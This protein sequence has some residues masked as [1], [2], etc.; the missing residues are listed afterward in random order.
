M[1]YQSMLFQVKCSE[2]ETHSHGQLKDEDIVCTESP[3][4]LMIKVRTQ[5]RRRITLLSGKFDK[6]LSILS[7]NLDIE[8]LVF[9][10]KSASPASCSF[11][12]GNRNFYLEID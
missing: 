7:I 9:H 6:D 4:G 11:L 10:S 1:Q 2:P 8:V 3:F 5:L 12:G